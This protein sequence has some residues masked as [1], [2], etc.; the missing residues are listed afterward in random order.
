M[1]S[2]PTYIT[3]ETRSLFTG[4]LTANKS[5]FTCPVLSTT[6]TRHSLIVIV[7]KPVGMSSGSHFEVGK[8]K[9]SSGHCTE[10]THDPPTA[11]AATLVMVLSTSPSSLKKP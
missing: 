4:S 7:N 11:P 6:G 1:G 5:M 2:H 3:G 8:A 9:M 10:M